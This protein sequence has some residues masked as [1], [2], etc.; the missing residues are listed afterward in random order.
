VAADTSF[1]ETNAVYNLATVPS[2]VL[3]FEAAYQK[4]ATANADKLQIFTSTDCGITW[5]SRRVITGT[6]LASLAGGISSSPY[7]PA[8]AAFTT[9]TVNINGV[10]NSH[11]VM[12][13]WQFMADPTNPGNNLYIDNINIISSVTGIEQIT[14]STDITIYP[15]PNNGSFV[16]E[17][18]S[19]AKQ[20]LQMYDINGKIVLSQIINGKSNIDAGN[21][22]A[23]VYNISIMSNEGIVN[24]RL[25][26]VK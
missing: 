5:V 13:R 25:V 10:A 14:N 2:P 21:L 9:Y 12:F 23:G 1:L 20:T 11:N 16:I 17:L 26:I 8:P 24:K 15:N 7:I 4:K 19:N 3:M 22:N 18:N 6:T